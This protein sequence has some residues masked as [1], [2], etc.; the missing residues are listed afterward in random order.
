MGS[1]RPLLRRGLSLHERQNER[2]AVVA[3]VAEELGHHRLQC[4]HQLRTNADTEVYMDEKDNIE[5][6][7]TNFELTQYLRKNSKVYLK[8]FD[9]LERYGKEL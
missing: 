1:C 9:T 7:W 5:G 2:N 4:F 3:A 6:V 8:Q